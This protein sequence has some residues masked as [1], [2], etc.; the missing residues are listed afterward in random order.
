MGIAFYVLTVILKSME[1]VGW[2]ELFDG[3]FICLSLSYRLPW[4]RAVLP[5]CVLRISELLFSSIFSTVVFILLS[6]VRIEK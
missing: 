6:C 2:C 4:V 5:V 1:I 3:C